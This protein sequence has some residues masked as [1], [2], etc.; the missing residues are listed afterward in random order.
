MNIFLLFS[1]SLPHIYPSIYTHPPTHPAVHTD[2][3]TNNNYN[4]TVKSFDLTLIGNHCSPV[5]IKSARSPSLSTFSFLGLSVLYKFKGEGY[6]GSKVDGTG[7][8]VTGD[9]R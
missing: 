4:V 1:T 5:L 6:V 7:R 3:R 9:G 2:R 8:E